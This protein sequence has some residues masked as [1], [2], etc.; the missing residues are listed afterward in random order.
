[1]GGQIGHDSTALNRTPINARTFA[2]VLVVGRLDTVWHIHTYVHTCPE[3][4]AAHKRQ[5]EWAT[6]QRLHL[7]DMSGV[8]LQFLKE[9]P[10]L[11]H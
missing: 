3:S 8:S 6:D 2:V 5:L 1:M 9:G 7:Q 10:G 4:D 11:V